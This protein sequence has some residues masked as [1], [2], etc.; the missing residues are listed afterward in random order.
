M[1]QAP[2]KSYQNL[3]EKVYSY[4]QEQIFRFWDELAEN[5]KIEFLKQ[6]NTINFDLLTKLSKDVLDNS[7]TESTDIKLDIAD[8]ISIYEREKS[9]SKAL[10]IGESLLNQGKMAAFLVAGGQG[11]R[12]GYDGPKGMYPV[13][14][15]KK[16][17][18]F[19]LHAEKL[20]ATGRKYN[21]PISWFIMTS[22]SNH[23]QTVEFFK[24]NNYFGY[25]KSYIDFFSQE[26]IPAID[27]NGKII[28]DAK[29]HIFTNP[30][31]HGGSLSALWISGAIEKMKS[32][33]IEYIFYF[34]VDNVLANNYSCYFQ[35]YVILFIWVIML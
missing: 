15:V 32:R 5:E 25:D 20:I 14:P 16:K 28:L 10:K 27:N 13:T 9:D 11:T 17:S 8:I 21:N 33:G 18:L 30:N 6:I 31:G 1:I 12:L 35:V 7:N 22:E 19:Q 34:Q 2:D 23:N 26:M 3:I 4:R 29:N 24:Q